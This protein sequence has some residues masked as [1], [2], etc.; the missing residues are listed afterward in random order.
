MGRDGYSSSSF[1]VAEEEEQE[2]KDYAWPLRQQRARAAV[3]G[4]MRMEKGGC[5]SSSSSRPRAVT[6]LVW[7]RDGFCSRLAP[8]SRGVRRVGRRV[9][10]A[11]WRR[12]KRL[13]GRLLRRGGGR[14]RR[15][16]RVG[17]SGGASSSSRKSS[18]EW[19]GKAAKV[20]PSFWS[21]DKE[22]RWPVQ[23]W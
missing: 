16:L 11:L 13:S 12:V 22:H 18:L 2:E 9:V 20:K 10:L 5:S 6:V 19:P 4:Y 14:R 3:G 21:V 7:S 8:A 15:D 23:G 1:Q 17:S